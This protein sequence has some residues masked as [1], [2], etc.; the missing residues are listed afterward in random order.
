MLGKAYE[1][2]VG[3]LERKVSYRECCACNACFDQNRAY[4][5]RC[6]RAVFDIA[7]SRPLKTASCMSFSLNIY[8]TAMNGIKS[9]F[10]LV[11]RKIQSYL[12]VGHPPVAL[13]LAPRFRGREPKA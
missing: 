12:K 4:Y 13:F 5:N 10:Q 6:S 2:A 3:R 11:K 9:S 7:R 1:G 8:M